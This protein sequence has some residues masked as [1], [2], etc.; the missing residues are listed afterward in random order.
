MTA[1]RRTTLIQGPP[2]PPGVVNAAPQ[3][4]TPGSI[5][6][7]A[8]ATTTVAVAGSLVGYPVLPPAWSAA[9]PDGVWLTAQCK[10]AGTITVYMFNNS[11]ST[12]NITAGQVY[13]E[14]LIN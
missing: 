7:T 5:L 4:W 10:V 3:N 8:F 13:V 9:L 6:N 2:G 12:Q 11:G 14:A 1:L